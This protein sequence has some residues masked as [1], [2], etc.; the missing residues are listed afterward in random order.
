MTQQLRLKMPV[1]MRV[2]TKMWPKLILIGKAMAVVANMAEMKV[3]NISQTI[4]TDVK[5][6]AKMIGK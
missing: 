4:K 2:V 3:G 1:M 5:I 6:A